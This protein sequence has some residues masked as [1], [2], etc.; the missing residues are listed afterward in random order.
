MLRK[1]LSL[2]GVL[3]LLLS[4]FA[5]SGGSAHAATISSRPPHAVLGCKP[6]FPGDATATWNNNAYQGWVR[7][8]EGS[9]RHFNFALQNCG[10]NGP[11]SYVVNF[12]VTLLSLNKGQWQT[13]DSRQGTRT[14]G[15][16]SGYLCT[17]WYDA[18]YAITDYVAGFAGSGYSGFYTATVD[19]VLGEMNVQLYN[20]CGN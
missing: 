1:I 10:P 9:D 5:F 3:A 15:G 7:P 19:Q 4:V 6:S 18:G 11:Y 13:S 2:F 8:V 20:A 12:H 16:V 17:N 14:W